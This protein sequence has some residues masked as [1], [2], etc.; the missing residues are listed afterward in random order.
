MHSVLIIIKKELKRF[1][2]DRRMLVSL[3]LPGIILYLVYSLMGNVMG[4]MLSADEAH[5]YN[6]AINVEDNVYTEGVFAYMKETSQLSFEKQVITNEEEAKTKLENGEV[7]LVVNYQKGDSGQLDRYEVLYNST[8]VEST[9]IYTEFV[10][11]LSSM[12]STPIYHVIPTDLATAE[13]TSMMIINMLLPFLLLTF[14][15]SGCMAVATESIAGEKERGTIATLLI[16]PVKRSYIALGKVIALSITALASATVS[17][18]SVILSLPKLMSGSMGDVEF[19]INYTVPEYLGIFA[20]IV[21]TVLLFTVA[22]SIVSTIAKSVKEATSYAMPVMILIMIVG[23]SGMLG[24]GSSN[25]TAC[26]IPIYN[27][28]QCMSMIFAQEFNPLSLIFTLLSNAV[29]ILLG[30]VALAKLFS[31]ERVMFNK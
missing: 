5:V 22:L 4:G 18:I 9:A 13:D 27:S 19:T 3:F 17:F 16:T 31:S 23:L 2:T 25:P 26:L 6:I 7:D 29:V 14:L 15:F 10:P 28:V 30:I 11:L 12:A 20:V 21:I 24:G 1:F 8:S